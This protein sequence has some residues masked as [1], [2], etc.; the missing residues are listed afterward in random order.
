VFVHGL[1]GFG[2]DT[3]SPISYWGATAGALLP[4]LRDEGFDCSA[5]SVSAA[6]SAWDRACELYAAI[7][8]GRVDYGAAHSQ[9]YGHA[10]YGKTYEAMLPEWG[11]VDENGN[12][13]KV[14]LIAHSFGGA[15]ARLMGALL[16]NGSA[17]ERDAATREGGALSPLFAGGKGD[18]L[19]SLTCL[20]APHNGVSLLTM[21]EVNPLIA[22]GAAFLDNAQIDE[23]LASIGFTVGGRS[24]GDILQSAKTQDNAYYDLTIDGAKLV[25]QMTDLHPN[26][27]YF[28]YPVDGTDNGVVTDD[29]SIPMQ[30]SGSLIGRFTNAQAGIDD[31]W[32][33]NDGLVNTISATAPFGQAQQTVADAAILKPEY[34][35][36]ASWYVMPTVR[37]DHGSIVGLGRTQAQTLPLYLE[38]M[39]R[40]DALSL[41]VTG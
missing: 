38:Q 31:R 11:T 8:G 1:N 20:A 6:G 3:G 22:L 10:R 25:G 4:K 34:L 17:A 5:P 32:K 37:G 2:D 27:Y 12:L 40:I 21:A 29:M 36:P 13:R 14:N 9:Q 33:P 26:T 24:L 7:A 28:S 18:W 35:A 41:Y 30:L 16:Q 23:A 39:Q 19:F 15:T